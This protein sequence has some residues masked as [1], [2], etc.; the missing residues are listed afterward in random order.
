MK[1]VLLISPQPF[2][3]WRGSPI[4]VGFNL[5]ALTQSGYEVDLLTLPI[6]E[7]REVS[8][9][10]IIR[11]ANPLR[12]NDVPIG[13][14]LAKLFFDLLIILK[15]ISL[16]LKNRYDVI[17][18]IEEAG[19]IAVF[20]A[21]LFRTKAIFEKHSDPSSYKK[22]LLRNMIMKLYSFVEH[23]AVRFADAVIGT[24]A[25][26]VTQVESMGTATR[27]FHIFDIPSSL[28]EPATD[29]IAGLK[30]ELQQQP[31]EI[32]TTFVGSF[33]VYQGVDL[34]FE[35]IPRVLS[36]SPKVRF[37][38]IGGS[39]EEIVERKAALAKIGVVEKISFLGKI[40]P[41]LLPNY[42]A[43]SDILLSP[44]ISGVNTPL[45]ILDYM[46][47]GR[48]IVAT[49]V[50]SNRL[51][52]DEKTALFA[53]PD[54]IVFANAITSLSKDQAIR[55]TMGKAG[56]HLYETRYNFQNFSQRLAACYTYV[57]QNTSTPDS[58]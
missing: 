53:T 50:E 25:G 23:T 8:G 3:Q 45:K 2:F 44:R 20:L 37:V 55:D 15:G 35:A 22:G 4:R 33:A 41:D 5:L 48:P 26:L 18:G 46:K 49:D 11:V 34:M 13:P 54:P 40:A 51:L 16:C 12:I 9:A 58:S 14:S 56:R 21:K 27:A 17:H 42:L 29:D 30:R 57:L 39:D 24:G 6:G 43:A 52:V 36:E 28:S 19:M 10:N 1:R 31:D 7:N 47:V 32:L 38:I